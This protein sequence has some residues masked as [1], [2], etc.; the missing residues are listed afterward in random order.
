MR[1]IAVFLL[2]V[3]VL[4]HQEVVYSKHG[5]TEGRYDNLAIFKWLPLRFL[6]LKA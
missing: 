2:K 1:F 3:E 5:L 6:P 4:L